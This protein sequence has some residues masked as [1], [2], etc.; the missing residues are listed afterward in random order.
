MLFP[1][2]P[3]VV[4]TL[5][6]ASPAAWAVTDDFSDLNDTAN[7]AW[8]HLSGLTMSTGQAWD[9][10]G[11]N[12]RLT[13]PNNGFVSGGA[14]YGFVGSHVASLPLTDSYVSADFVVHTGNGAHGVYGVAARLNGL[15]GFNALKGYGYAYEPFAAGG[16]GEMVLYR[17]T[18]LN[19]Q[20]IGSQVVTL[21]PNKDYTFNLYITGTQ[22]HGWVQEV[23]G[24]IVASKSAVDATYTSGTAGVF[25]YSA[26]PVYTPTD[27]TIDNFSA[28][29]EPST[30]TVAALGLL[31]LAIGNARRLSRS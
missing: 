24:G 30:L 29:P 31:G 8:T 10:S 12:Y 4:A 22:L 13:A 19:I 3:A 6:A 5:I 11:A 1:V 2:S 26:N 17:I 14:Q 9:A 20:D 28:V 18:G 27:F 23:G 7:P 21:D 15:N 16:N 25:G